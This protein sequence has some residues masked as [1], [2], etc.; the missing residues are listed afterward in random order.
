MQTR[1]KTLILKKV[2]ITIVRLWDRSSQFDSNN[3]H[4]LVGV[5]RTGYKQLDELINH[6]KPLRVIFHL[7][8]VQQPDQCNNLVFV[9]T[10]SFLIDRA[11][12]WQLN[13]SDKFVR[14]EKLREEGNVQFKEVKSPGFK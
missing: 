8:E 11:D 7:I 10:F 4:H 13:E 12:N 6:P 2:S 5:S 9:L 3:N 14:V 1:I